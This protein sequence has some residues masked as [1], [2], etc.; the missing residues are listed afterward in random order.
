MLN[1]IDRA[2]KSPLARA[3]TWPHRPES[4]LEFLAPD[5]GGTAIKATIKAVRHETDRAVSLV[6]EPNHRWNG[7]IAGQYVP[8][9]V[10]IN[11]R[12]LSRCFTISHV[13]GG[14]PVVTIQTHEGGV[15]SAWANESV[16][17]G[18]I[19]EIGA[20][21]GD[22]VLPADRSAPFLMI[23]GGSGITPVRAMVDQLVADGHT[24]TVDILYYVPSSPEAIFLGHL[25]NIAD[26]HPNFRL[27]LVTTRGK[28]GGLTGHFST[29]HL[30]AIGAD[31]KV[32]RAYVC[33]PAA[34]IEAVESHWVD[35]GQHGRLTLERFQAVAR[36]VSTGGEGQPVRFDGSAVTATAPEG[37]TLLETAEAAGLTPMS[38]CRQGI[39]RTCTCRKLGG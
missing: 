7:H 1:L 21:A 10:A 12:R 9:T 20:A 14:C 25:K 38:G 34:L 3:L 15:V 37:R 24:G 27:H 36:P 30:K 2:L 17:T 22:F 33:G 4:Y 31:I 39:C 5:I 35:A 6:L 13:E 28:E 11:G 29:A 23:A 16:W 8:F 26:A 32:A 18:D 19:V